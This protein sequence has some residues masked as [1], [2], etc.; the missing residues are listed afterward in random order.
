MAG[1]TMRAFD[2]TKVDDSDIMTQPFSL[3]DTDPIISE[4]KSNVMTGEEF[5]KL[6]KISSSW[7]DP[8]WKKT[9]ASE[10][11]GTEKIDLTKPE[12][13]IASTSQGFIDE[14]ANFPDKIK[15]E[16]AQIVMEAYTDKNKLTQRLVGLFSRVMPQLPVGTQP[17]ELVRKI[18]EKSDIFKPAY[19]EKLVDDLD[20]R[21]YPLVDWARKTLSTTTKAIQ[22]RDLARAIQAEQRGIDRDA[23]SN[24][25]GTTIGAMM[26][27][28]ALGKGVGG[29]SKALGATVETAPKVGA[30]A[31]KAGTLAQ[32]TG[33][34]AYTTAAQYLD[35]TGDSDFTNFTPED[36]KGLSA[37][38]YGAIGTMIEYGF[39]GV[40]PLFASGMEKLGTSNILKAVGKT[41]AGEAWEEFLQEWDT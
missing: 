30:T 36:A 5:T 34:Y 17:D 32:M 9:S 14:V 16:T 23:W 22:D 7:N 11:F 40:E 8:A 6:G 26:P 29:I 15:N 41:M 38:G 20:G 28:I 2:L 25:L 4:K 1:E 37:L 24:Q 13:F 39:G 10:V 18:V 27:V 3:S 19:D 21:E 31:M 35:K 33:D 12:E